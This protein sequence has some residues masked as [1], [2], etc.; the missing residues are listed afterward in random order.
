[1][2][3]VTTQ[4]FEEKKRALTRGEIKQDSGAK[5]LMSILMKANM[6]AT[7]EDRLPDK[8]VLAQIQDKLRD[9]VTRLLE[10]NED[11]I[12][13]NEL[14]SLPFLDAVCRETLRLATED[15]LLPLSAPVK[16]VDDSS[17]DSIFIPKNTKVFVS[18]YNINRDP[19]L[20]GS[21]SSEWKPERWLSRLPQAVHDAHVP[22]VY[23][24]MMTFL[25][26]SHACIGFK[27]SELE[28]SAS[29]DD[30]GYKLIDN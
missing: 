17:I 10:G 27:F 13:Y 25:G 6:D 26:G 2:D 19:T 16:G 24:H 9:E 14:I 7:V 28:M 8:E 3:R 11:S 15:Y 20:W 30:D 22:G 23:S 4:I 21:D 29:T 5:D 1:M 12:P 18:I